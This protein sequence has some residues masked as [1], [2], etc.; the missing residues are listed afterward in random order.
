M[1]TVGAQTYV[2]RY[3]LTGLLKSFV[4]QGEYHVKNS[5]QFVEFIDSL[6]LESNDI[7]ALMWYLYLLEFQWKKP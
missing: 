4:G 5:A 7:V 3:Y 6:C 1:S 2:A